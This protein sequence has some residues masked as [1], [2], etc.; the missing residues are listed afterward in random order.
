MQ[1][2]RV[3][4]YRTDAERHELRVGTIIIQCGQVRVRVEKKMQ[5]CPSNRITRNSMHLPI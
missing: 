1:L 3:D 5:Y 4:T 2:N